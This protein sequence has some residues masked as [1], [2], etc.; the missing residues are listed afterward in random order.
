M[1]G[2]L[3]NASGAPKRSPLNHPKMK[4]AVGAGCEPGPNGH[5]S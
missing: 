5:V 3:A 1:S 2:R 4:V